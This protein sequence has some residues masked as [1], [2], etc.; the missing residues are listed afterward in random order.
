MSVPYKSA[1]HLFP[2]LK[3]GIYQATYHIGI[4]IYE[5]GKG[6]CGGRISLAQPYIWWLYSGLYVRITFKLTLYKV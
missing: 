4:M 3:G 5:V 2:Q 1:L 6:M